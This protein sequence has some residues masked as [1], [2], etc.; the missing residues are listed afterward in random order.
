MQS[1]IYQISDCSTTLSIKFPFFPHT[2]FQ[3]FHLSSMAAGQVSLKGIPIVEPNGVVVIMFC[4][5]VWAGGVCLFDPGWCNTFFYHAHSHVMWYKWK[6][7]RQWSGAM[8]CRRN[9]NFQADLP[10]THHEINTTFWITPQKLDLSK[11]RLRTN[12]LNSLIY[13]CAWANFLFMLLLES[14]STFSPCHAFWPFYH[15]TLD[16]TKLA[17]P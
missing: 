13:L 12:V 4:L 16:E 1:S 6:S 14:Y 11:I 7:Q 2:A 5:H 8:P 3:K 15:V 10:H 9:S 17:L